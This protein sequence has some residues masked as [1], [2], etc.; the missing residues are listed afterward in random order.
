MLPK[1]S[2]VDWPNTPFP[3]EG[4]HG[5]YK[6]RGSS[7]Q[8]Q[9]NTKVESYIE[10]RQYATSQGNPRGEKTEGNKIWQVVEQ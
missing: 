8:Q 4:L 10:T 2:V 1:L 7:W 6:D 9:I 3:L 5:R